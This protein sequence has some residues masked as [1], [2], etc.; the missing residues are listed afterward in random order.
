MSIL[1]N[2]SDMEMVLEEVN[3]EQVK[4]VEM[5]FSDIFGTMKSVTIP[6]ESIT[7]VIDEGVSIDGS[8]I[9]GFATVEESEFKGRPIMNTFKIYPWTC[10]T[11][12][13][14]ARLV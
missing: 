2:T 8:S 13:K 1:E 14:T 11:D 4:F 9:L 6:S 3:K 12:Q 7:E 5:Q 10:G